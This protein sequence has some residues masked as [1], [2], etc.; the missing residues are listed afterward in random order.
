MEFTRKVKCVR[1]PLSHPYNAYRE[2]ERFYR[3]ANVIG[4]LVDNTIDY[5]IE[6]S[7][8]AKS[9]LEGAKKVRHFAWATILWFSAH[10]GARGVE[11]FEGH[12]YIDR[13][14]PPGRKREIFLLVFTRNHSMRSKIGC[15]NTAT[16]SIGRLVATPIHSA[17]PL[18]E[19]NLHF[20]GLRWWFLVVGAPWRWYGSLNLPIQLTIRQGCAFAER[21]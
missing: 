19:V 5:K 15:T 9:W 6:M 18:N 12:W 4:V 16:F 10:L 7:W 20:V 14:W 17:Q 8:I 1:E 2:V 13:S 21:R 11:L 3:E